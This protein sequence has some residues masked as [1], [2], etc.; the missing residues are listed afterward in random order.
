[1]LASLHA[2][3]FFFKI[4]KVS[5]QAVEETRDILSLR[6]QTR[7]RGSNDCRIQS[8]PLRDVDSSGCSGNADLQFVSRLQRGFI[9][10]DRSVDHSRRIRAIDFERSVV[11]GD[12]DHA[13]DIAKVLG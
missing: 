4:A 2:R 7:A 10:A 8:K 12:H 9:K 13:S 1:M 6:A 11:R 5:M 3:A